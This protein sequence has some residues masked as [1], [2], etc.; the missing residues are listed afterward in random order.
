MNWRNHTIN[1]NNKKTRASIKQFQVI[2]T[3][4]SS[5]SFPLL[6]SWVTLSQLKWAIQ[7]L[8]IIFILFD[9]Y[10]WLSFILAF[11]LSFFLDYLLLY[12]TDL[13]FIS[14]VFNISSDSNS[15]SIITGSSTSNRSRKK[16]RNDNDIAVKVDQKETSKLRR[17]RP[18]FFNAINAVT[19]IHLDEPVWT[20][21]LWLLV[22]LLLAAYVHKVYI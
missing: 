20:V 7:S 3:L 22:L 10:T 17:Q 21:W 5:F 12:I 15:N 2:E 13:Q 16:K 6:Y 4:A 1:S 8:Y 9:L 11:I 14:Y 18:I 19:H